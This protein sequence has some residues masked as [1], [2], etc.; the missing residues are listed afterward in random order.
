V[1]S[2]INSFVFILNLPYELRPFVINKEY[3]E[4]LLPDG[5]TLSAH[6]ASANPIVDSASQ[7]QQ[8]VLTVNDK[9]LP[10]NLVAKVR[11]TKTSKAIT[12]SL[13]RQA[14]LTDETQTLFWVMKLTNDSM[15]IKVPVTKGMEMGDRIEILSPT[16]NFND[17]FLLTGNFGLPDTARIKII[18]PTT[19]ERE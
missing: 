12:V 5:K 19:S 11:V 4:L 7:T 1:I 14:V 10:I 3:V 13:P 18:G 6:I 9:S 16:F 15:A 17:R 2:D 8:L